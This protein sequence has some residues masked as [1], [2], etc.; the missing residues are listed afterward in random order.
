MLLHYLRTIS[1][2]L[3]SSTVKPQ[4]DAAAPTALHLLATILQRGAPWLSGIALPPSLVQALSTKYG[5]WK[6]A[7][8]GEATGVAPACMLTGPRTCPPNMHTLLHPAN[9]CHDKPI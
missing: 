9:L 6:P 7:A 2:W 1:E 8:A 3:I 4:Q 5:A